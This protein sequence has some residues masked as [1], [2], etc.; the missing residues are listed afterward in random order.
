MTDQI[1]NFKTTPLVDLPH[2]HDGIG[3]LNFTD[4]F[5]GQEFSAHIRFFHHTI[6]PVGTSIGMHKHED[7]QEF[8]VVLDGTGIMN[9]DGTE[10][11]VGPGDVIVNKPFGEHGL[12][13]T[14]DIPMEL[15]VFEIANR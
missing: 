10:Y 15:L 3:V 1:R 13:N 7:D 8:Y 2:C 9:L 4:L 6:L 14:G 5:A 11:P 12:F